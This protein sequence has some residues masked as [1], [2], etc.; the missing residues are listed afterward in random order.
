MKQHAEHRHGRGRPIDW[1]VLPIYS[2]LLISA[3][4]IMAL[5]G[6]PSLPLYRP[7]D[8]GSEMPHRPATDALIR[9]INATAVDALATPD[10]IKEIISVSGL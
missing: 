6:V 9:R 2:N 1:S 7:I 3:S 8:D 10:D 5:L 4:E